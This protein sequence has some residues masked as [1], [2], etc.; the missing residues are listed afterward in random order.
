MVYIS[1]QISYFLTGLRRRPKAEAQ[2][3]D[4]RV[5]EI[6]LRYISTIVNNC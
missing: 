6:Y 3:P 2:S 5:K 4:L 1:I